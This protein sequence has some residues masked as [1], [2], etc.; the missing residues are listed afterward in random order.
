MTVTVSPMDIRWGG[1]I[2][3]R[4]NPPTIEFSSPKADVLT[5]AGLG[6]NLT[7]SAIGNPN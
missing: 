5:L 4:W 2:R 3:T 7:A 1:A 6:I